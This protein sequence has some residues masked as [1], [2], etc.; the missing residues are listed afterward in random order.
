MRSKSDKVLTESWTVEGSPK[1][2]LAEGLAGDLWRL[3]AGSQ[4]VTASRLFGFSTRSLL[5]SLAR[6]PESWHS[7]QLLIS[8]SWEGVSIGS[9]FADLHIELQADT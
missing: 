7:S 1:S 5:P 3:V 9:I 4:K 2:W 6:V 8:I